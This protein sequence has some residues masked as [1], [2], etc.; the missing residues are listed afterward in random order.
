MHHSHFCERKHPIVMLFDRCGKSPSRWMRI[1]LHRIFLAA[2][3]RGSR[4]GQKL[5]SDF[6]RDRER[7]EKTQKTNCFLS[8]YVSNDP[9][10]I[11]ISLYQI[12]K[13]PFGQVWKLLIYHTSDMLYTPNTIMRMHCQSAA[14]ENNMANWMQNDRKEKEGRGYIDMFD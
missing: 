9:R 8:G 4:L 7:I 5:K 6:S 14:N 12:R 11:Y 3:A 1:A 13:R 10:H 2:I